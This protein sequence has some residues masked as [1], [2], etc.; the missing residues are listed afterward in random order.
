MYVSGMD[1]LLVDGHPGSSRAHINAGMG[2]LMGMQNS[3]AAMGGFA[4]GV[5][6]YGLGGVGMQSPQMGAGFAPGGNG[7]FASPTAGMMYP[8]NMSLGMQ[9]MG[10]GHTVYAQQMPGMGYPAPQQMY[11]MGGPG[12]MGMGVP[13]M[14]AYGG[15]GYQAGGMGMV[16]PGLDA[17]KKESIDR[18]RMSVLQ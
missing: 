13:A 16:D 5:Y 14:A 11:G 8:S 6:N 4:G 10:M 2:G 9:A 3:A 17:K 15:M 1:R 7:Y 12:A 18:W